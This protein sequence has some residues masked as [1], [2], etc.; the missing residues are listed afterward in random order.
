MNFALI[1]SLAMLYTVHGSHLM[2]DRGP[3]LR[4]HSG[5]VFKPTVK[6]R[7]IVVGHWTHSF[8]L[9]L[10]THPRETQFREL[11]NC[12]RLEPHNQTK[13]IR[14]K[15]IVHALALI[16]HNMSQIQS[17]LVSRTICYAKSDCTL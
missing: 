7:P 12:L 5:A 11:N 10:P 13:C 8:V 16:Q 6:F 3:V 4:Q 2:H 14:A 9:T 17:Q 15:P 1:L